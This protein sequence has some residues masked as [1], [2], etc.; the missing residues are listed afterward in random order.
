MEMEDES[1]DSSSS[2]RSDASSWESDAPWAEEPFEEGEQ[3]LDPDLRAPIEPPT[4]DEL[5]LDF[6][7]FLDSVE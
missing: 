7:A 4:E 6:A 2:S 1:S 5:R 3:E